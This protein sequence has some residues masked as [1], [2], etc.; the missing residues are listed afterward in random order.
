MGYHNERSVREP[1]SFLLQRKRPGHRHDSVRSVALVLTTYP[2][3]D[4]S[5][6]LR[7]DPVI[8]ELRERG[9]KVDVDA[10]F[11]ARAFRWKNRGCV[12]KS[13]AILL[14]VVG[15]LKR[16]RL[17]WRRPEV[18]I[19]HREAFPFSTPRFERHF[20]A[21]S[22]I[23]VLD[24]DD[25]VYSAPTHVRDWRRIFRTPE[26]AL[27]FGRIFDLIV[28]G[29]A[30]L[31]E[32]FSGHG[33][34]CIEAPTCP[35]SRLG[36]SRHLS[37]DRIAFWSGSFSTLGNL[38]E[39]LDEVM[40]VCRQ[41]DVKLHV[42]GGQNVFSLPNEEDIIRELWTREREREL[43]GRALVGLMPL[44]ES[45][46]D[47]GKSSYKAIMYL[48]A[49]LPCVV[50][51]L[52]ENIRLA[53]SY[54]IVFGARSGQFGQTLS[55]TLSVIDSRS[56]LEDVSRAREVYDP[57]RNASRTV[58]EVLERTKSKS[59]EEVALGRPTT[60]CPVPPGVP[61]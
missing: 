56:G 9:M 34:V 16:L 47:R 5:R 15:L 30:S 51:L 3:S 32:V 2:S 26:R 24:V 43:L 40:V 59:S 33:G 38:T 58:D 28:C 52:G 42:L 50:T 29:N 13:V 39:V 49:G 61:I 23:A 45:P 31:K 57:K 35:E 12:K 10:I 1:S 53:K 60:N 54:S 11:S 36:S 48:C 17:L 37:V 25:A 22:S 44:S 7:I 6:F 27:E 4:A 18:L 21:R 55:D 20:A 41:F 46:W 8:A 19:V 14:V